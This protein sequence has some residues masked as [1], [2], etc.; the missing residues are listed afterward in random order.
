MVAAAIRK[1]VQVQWMRWKCQ[2]AS[3]GFRGH[4]W[5]AAGARRCLIMW[6]LLSHVL[7]YVF[8]SLLSQ[9]SVPGP[10]HHNSGSQQS[11]LWSGEGFKWHVC[12]W[13]EGGG[14]PATLGARRKRRSVTSPA[15]LCIFTP[16][17]W[18]C[19]NSLFAAFE[20]CIWRPVTVLF[21]KIQRMLH[22]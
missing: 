5:A 10:I 2:R 14:R 11:H 4:W 15:S 21:I 13:E 1:I 19:R 9:R 18:L 20:T 6:K 22:I 8:S 7:N 16:S 3:P 17:Q 12:G